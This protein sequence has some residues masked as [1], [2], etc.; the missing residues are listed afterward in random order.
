M[1]AKKTKATESDEIKTDQVEDVNVEPIESETDQVE[2][3]DAESIEPETNLVEDVATFKV[4]HNFKDAKASEHYKKGD[5][6]EITVKHANEINK[7]SIEKYYEAFVERL[8]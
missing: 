8:E 5:E 6:I 3:K 2:D 4:L 1:A 7:E